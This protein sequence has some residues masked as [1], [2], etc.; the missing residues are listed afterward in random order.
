MHHY[1]CRQTVIQVFKLDW[2]H[3]TTDSETFWRWTAYK[4]VF[5]YHYAALAK[6]R[7]RSVQYC[8]KRFF[9]DMRKC[10][11]LNQIR[12]YDLYGLMCFLAS[13]FNKAE[14]S[15]GRSLKKITKHFYRFLIKGKKRNL[16]QKACTGTE[17][18]DRVHNK[19]YFTL[20]STQLR[21][22]WKIFLVVSWLAPIL[23]DFHA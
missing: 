20:L 8:G 12:S 13:K 16:K 11:N 3:R 4:R 1:R 7:F 14:C 15:A 5:Q 23:S 2:K 19:G 18:W 21:H 22:L 9:V 10:S 6:Y 17:K